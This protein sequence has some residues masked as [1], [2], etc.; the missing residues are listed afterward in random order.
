VRDAT[1]GFWMATLCFGVLITS[2]TATVCL[3]IIAYYQPV[4]EKIYPVLVAF[5]AGALMMLTAAT[6]LDRHAG[7]RHRDID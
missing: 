4:I 3:G 1:L 7:S 5:A 2:L 6:Q